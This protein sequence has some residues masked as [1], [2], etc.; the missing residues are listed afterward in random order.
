M[1]AKFI[2][3]EIS[4]KRHRSEEE[5]KRTLFGFRPGHLVSSK[6]S[7]D[8]ELSGGGGVSD[9]NY[10]EYCYDGSC[11]VSGF[12]DVVFP[13]KSSSEPV[14]EPI[15][16]PHIGTY[17]STR[18]TDTL[19]A[20]DPDEILAIHRW[21]ETDQGQ[22]YLQTKEKGFNLRYPEKGGNLKI[23]IPEL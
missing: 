3:E 2:R 19:R 8:V 6:R 7:K 14:R 22:K 13:P 10:I 12:G 5:I 23:K 9:I 15:F 11:I 1:R 17:N 20:L 4:F 18:D 16:K 21:L